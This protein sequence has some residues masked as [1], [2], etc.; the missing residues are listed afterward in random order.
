MSR[1]A[2]RS[3]KRGDELIMTSGTPGRRDGQTDTAVRVVTVGRKYVHVIVERFHEDYLADP[4]K[5]GSYVR[6]FLIEDQ[7]EG[8]RS[9]RI[10]YSAKVATVEQ[11]AYDVLQ[12]GAAKYLFD[13]GI[14]VEHRS[15]WRGREVELAT[16][17]KAAV[18]A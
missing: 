4:D 18:D 3:L 6:K 12:H 10:G 2:L 5:Y 9:T 14:T 1:P 16:A 11:H 7:K 17:L 15:P 8:E 13:Q